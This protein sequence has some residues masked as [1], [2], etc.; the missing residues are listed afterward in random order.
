[1]LPIATGDALAGLVPEEDDR[2]DR[3]RQHR[4]GRTAGILGPVQ[5]APGGSGHGPPTLSL[6]RCPESVPGVLDR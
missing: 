2:H 1:M 6:V 5:Q 3:R 4:N